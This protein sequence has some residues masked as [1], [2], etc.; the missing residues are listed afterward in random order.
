MRILVTGAN[1]QLG[2]SIQQRVSEATSDEWIFSDRHSLPL[3]T[4]DLK[5]RLINIKPDIIIHCAAYTAVDKAET[6]KEKAMLINAQATK[7]IALAASHCNAFLIYV[8]TDFVFDGQKS[9]P[10]TE[11]DQPSPINVYGQSKWQGELLVCMHCSRHLILRTSWVYAEFGHNFVLTMMRLL[12][13]KPE[14]RVVYDQI[15]S[16]TYAGDIADFI[17]YFC[18]L[19][20]EEQVAGTYHFSNEGVAGWYDFA[21]AIRE[22][23]SL[24]TPVFPIS[25]T[26]YP[27]AAQRPSYSVLS[28]SKLKKTFQWTVPYWRDSL[29]YC[30]SKMIG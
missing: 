3:E 24:E 23:I 9:S 25:S 16:P 26:D 11:D 19:P 28:K 20:A 10:Y 14:L 30:I 27:A 5:A 17:I 7:N 29:K 21:L 4:P 18:T 15:G 2:R 8:S 6:E 22:L 1:G 13:E 12:K